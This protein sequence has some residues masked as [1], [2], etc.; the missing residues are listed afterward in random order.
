MCL[1]VILYLNNKWRREKSHVSLINW[2]NIFNWLKKSWK[3][4]LNV[5]L[6]I[7]SIFT[8]TSNRDYISQIQLWHKRR[9]PRL[10]KIG[11]L[12]NKLNKWCQINWTVL[13]LVN[14]LLLSKTHIRNYIWNQNLAWKSGFIHLFLKFK[15]VKINI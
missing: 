7:I 15:N 5:A 2:T 8:E 13:L 4:V 6:K 1:T 10:N 14:C 3:V 11:I 12:K 9:D